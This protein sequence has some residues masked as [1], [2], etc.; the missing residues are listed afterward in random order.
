MHAERPSAQPRA[1]RIPRANRRHARLPQRYFATRKVAGDLLTVPVIAE[2]IGHLIDAV[3]NVTDSHARTL[4]ALHS[5]PIS[6]QPVPGES[7][8]LVRRVRE[9]LRKHTP[10][11]GDFEFNT[12]EWRGDRRVAQRNGQSICRL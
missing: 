8:R 2:L 3:V 11:N 4:A 9:G 1:A 6:I 12:F 5:A 7:G 10:G